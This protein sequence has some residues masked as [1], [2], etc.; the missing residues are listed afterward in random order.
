MPES[1]PTPGQTQV[2]VYISGTVQ[3]VGYRYS[4]VHKAQ[5][6]GIKGW[7]RNLHDGRVEA[8]F[9]GDRATVKKMINWCYDGP[10]AAQ[11]RDIL[12]EH[13]QPQGLPNFETRY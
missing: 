1:S 11:V 4:T 12:I 9:E 7:V 8:V 2:R 3:G 10:P 6:L 13:R 5:Q